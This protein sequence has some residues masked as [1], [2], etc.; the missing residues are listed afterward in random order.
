VR[1][2]NNLIKLLREK[3]MEELTIQN[4]DKVSTVICKSNPE[5]GTKRFNHNEQPLNDGKSVSTCGNSILFENE[6]KYWNVST[7]KN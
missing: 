7:W 4:A 2:V 6:Y 1:Q 5:W 3:K